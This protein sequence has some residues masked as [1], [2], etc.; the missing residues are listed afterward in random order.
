MNF[1]KRFLLIASIIILVANSKSIGQLQFEPILMG[2]FGYEYNIFKAP[3]V[4][5][6]NLGDPIPESELIQS[7]MFL[8][9][10][11]NLGFLYK[12][13]KHTFYVDQGFWGRHYINYQSLNQYGINLDLKYKY[14]I[15]KYFDTG[16]K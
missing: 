3:N 13:K 9:Y 1:N 7:D 16:I 14:K 2:Q 12:V 11:Y 5:L 8:D 4:L 15:S 10:G 6:D